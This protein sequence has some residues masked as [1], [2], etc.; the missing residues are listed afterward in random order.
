MRAEEPNNVS[1]GAVEERTLVFRIGQER[2]GM[3][4]SVIREVFQ[5]PS[6]P[7]PVAGAPAWLRGIT[8]HHGQVVPV[9]ALGGILSVQS[10]PGIEQNILVELLDE[11][12]ALSVNQIES[13][14]DVRP[15]GP[16]RQGR[17]QAWH[18]GA[19]LTLLEP[20][21]LAE[22]IRQHL[23]ESHR[24]VDAGRCP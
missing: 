23:S 12:I 14:E 4:L 3:P 2:F 22:V 10:G 24:V 13:L 19:L 21:S 6:P 18:R 17:S 8:T 16:M 5:M 9:I 11:V 15:T 20:Q 7:I 1:Y